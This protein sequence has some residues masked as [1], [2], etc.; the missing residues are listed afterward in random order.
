MALSRKKRKR[1]RARALAGPE[2]T[3]S[4]RAAQPARRPGARGL[5]GDPAALRRSDLA[6]IRQAAN[7]G[8]HVPRRVR[9][10]LV[11]AAVARLA[12]PGNV[13]MQ[14]AAARAL[15]AMAASNGRAAD[16]LLAEGAAREEW[17]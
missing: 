6:L 1:Y 14:L 8:W 2:A 9:R 16:R 5:W 11:D 10:R 12:A 4:D 7:Q 15:V 17:H 13:R 3:A